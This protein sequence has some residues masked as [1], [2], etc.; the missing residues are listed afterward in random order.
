MAD[1]GAI[2]MF[3]NEGNGRLVTTLPRVHVVLMGME[4]I[5]PSLAELAVMA[6]LLPR[7]ATGQKLT[8]YL[9]LVAGP[10]RTGEL[11]GP[12]ELHVVIFDNGRSAQI[13]EPRLRD[14]CG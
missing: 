8:T 1:T 9:N 14:I 13:S 3:T 11:D 6:E 7:S 2:A 12:R 5:V 4:R 10:R